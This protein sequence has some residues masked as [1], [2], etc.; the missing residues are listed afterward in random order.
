PNPRR[1][2]LAGKLSI[3][4]PGNHEV[5]L[6]LA[7]KNYI[8]ASDTYMVKNLVD[9]P[10]AA[11]PRSPIARFHESRANQALPQLKGF[12][13]RFSRDQDTLFQPVRNVPGDRAL[14]D[15]PSIGGV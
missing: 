13:A 14:V 15:N 11:I 3:R 1:V 6:T 2:I 5:F 9:L 8:V 10:P 7:I 4:R 12:C